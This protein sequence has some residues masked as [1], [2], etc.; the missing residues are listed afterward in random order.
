MKKSDLPTGFPGNRRCGACKVDTKMMNTKLV[1]DVGTI[2]NAQ[3]IASLGSLQQPDGFL[4]WPLHEVVCVSVL[5]VSQE[6]ADPPTFSLSSFSRQTLTEAMIID[7]IERRLE[8]RVDCVVTFNGRCFDLP[9]LQLR[10]QANGCITPKLRALSATHGLRAGAVHLDLLARLCPLGA[11]PKAPL[12]DVCAALSIPSKSSVDAPS[13]SAVTVA[14][15]KWD[16]IQQFC[17]QDVLSTWLLKLSLDAHE[18]DDF[19]SLRD[20]WAALAKWL[21]AHRDR[22]EHLRPFMTMPTVGFPA[23]SGRILG[24][25]A[26]NGLAF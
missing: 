19:H 25:G 15:D 21:E 10:S 1:L 13:S 23:T 6:R 14:E 5:T 2:S 8:N 16:R 18:L 24:T 12:A 7:G 9:V 26:V 17:E 22:F 3:A 20:G 4:S 11:A